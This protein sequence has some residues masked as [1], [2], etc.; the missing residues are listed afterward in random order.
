MD[1]LRAYMKRMDPP[2][3]PS[4]TYDKVR[5]RLLKVEEF[6]AISSE[7]L[8]QN[9]FDKFIRRLNEKDDEGGDR[10]HR[11]STDR[12]LSRRER[13][14]SRGERSHRSS[15]R[16]GRRS[17]SPELDPY[18]ADRRRAIAERERNHR[19]TTMAETLLSP[20]RERERERGGGSS[21]R[22][23]PPP[24]RRGGDRERERERDPRGDRDYDRPP[25]SRRDEDSHYDRERRDREE[26]RE[27]QFRR[28]AADRGSYDELPYGDERPAGSRRRRQDEEDDYARRDSRDSKV[29]FP[30]QP[31]ALSFCRKRRR[32]NRDK[33][34]RQRRERSRE[35]SPPRESGRDRKKTP[36]ASAGAAEAAPAEKEDV[37]SGSEE[38]EIEE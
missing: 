15:G 6:Q 35:R 14:R 7:D 17:R 16:P 38:G 29:R 28:R 3:L 21:G 34:Q 18:E 11:R 36:P 31:A 19:K 20:G 8:R 9:A 26:D 33:K 27:R 4:D 2:I 22:P 23:S 12:D 10:G 13:D 5:P 37:V 32:A 30:P 1:D 24:P 25:R